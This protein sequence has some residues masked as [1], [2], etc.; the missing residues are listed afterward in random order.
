MSA[1]AYTPADEAVSEHPAVARVHVPTDQAPLFHVPG[2]HGGWFISLLY[3]HDSDV[4][5]PMRT[6]RRLLAESR[7]GVIVARRLTPAEVELIERRR[8]DCDADV[9]AGIIAKERM[10]FRRPRRGGGWHP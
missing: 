2:R 6:L 10:R 7:G 8:L 9:H 5:V 3:G 1:K 4:I